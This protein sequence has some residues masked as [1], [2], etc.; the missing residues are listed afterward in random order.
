MTAEAAEAGLKAPKTDTT[1]KGK[2]DK[3]RLSVSLLKN[4]QNKS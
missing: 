2:T 4:S 1:K 3:D